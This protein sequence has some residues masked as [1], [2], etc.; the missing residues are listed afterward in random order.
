MKRMESMNAVAE[1]SLWNATWNLLYCCY[2]ESETAH[3]CTW[4]KG[5]HRDLT[6]RGDSRVLIPQTDDSSLVDRLDGHALRCLK[7]LHGR[8]QNQVQILLQDRG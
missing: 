5:A 4:D 7:R 8:V 3:I 6:R 1:A 2:G